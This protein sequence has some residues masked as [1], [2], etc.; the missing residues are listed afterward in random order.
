MIDMNKC[1]FDIGQDFNSI[2]Q[3]LTNI[4]CFPQGRIR[5][6]DNVDFNE[7]RWSTLQITRVLR[8]GK[9]EE[10]L[11]TDMICP[12]SINLLNIFAERG[13]LVYQE[14]QEFVRSRLA[15]EETKLSINGDAP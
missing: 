4:V 14:L 11:L 10:T 8:H 1:P 15:C 2:L 5:F 13:S 3:Q 9:G 6:H 12:H 7:I